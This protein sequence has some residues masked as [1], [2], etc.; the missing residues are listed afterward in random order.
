M[1]KHL[2]VIGTLLLVAGI[3]GYFYAEDQGGLAENIEGIFGDE[4]VNWS[5]VSSMSIAA[6]VLGLV[7]L[8][9]GLI[10]EKFYGT[11]QRSSS[12]I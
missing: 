10:P 8:I 3:F 12:E 5:L 4:G 2:V 1:K 7:T 11:S 6:A 9:L